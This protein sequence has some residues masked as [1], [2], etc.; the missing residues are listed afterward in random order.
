MS[1][2]SFS[3]FGKE[4]ILYVYE[5]VLE[6]YENSDRAHY[7]SEILPIGSSKVEFI[8]EN[9]QGA[10]Q[11]FRVYNFNGVNVLNTANKSD[12]NDLP[13]GLYII[14]VKKTIIK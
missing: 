11:Y 4:V 9:S 2:A 8:K 6:D 1:A 13:R 14:N 5:S 10:N 7:F 12:L 3:Y